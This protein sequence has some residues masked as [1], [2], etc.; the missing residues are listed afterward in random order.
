MIPPITKRP[1]TELTA[2]PVVVVKKPLLDVAPRKLMLPDIP[3]RSSTETKT[4]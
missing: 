3:V 2:I 4:G 1:A